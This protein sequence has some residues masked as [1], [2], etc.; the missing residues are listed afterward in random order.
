M[1]MKPYHVSYIHSSHHF[2]TK[3]RT[4]VKHAL[5]YARNDQQ[6][7]DTASRFGATDIYDPAANIDGAARYLRV[8]LDKL[9]NLPL[10]AAAYN[11]G[12][13]AVHDYH[14][15]PR[16]SEN[17]GCLAG[18]LKDQLGLEPP[19]DGKAGQELNLIQ[20]RETKPENTGVIG[21][22]RETF[23][24]ACPIAPRTW[25]GTRI[26]IDEDATARDV[27]YTRPDRAFGLL[28]ALCEAAVAN[29]VD[30][31]ISNYEPHMRRI[32]KKP[33]PNS[34][35]SGIPMVMALAGLLGDLRGF[36]PRSWRHAHQ[37]P[38]EGPLYQRPAFPS[39]IAA[40]PALQFS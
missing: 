6:L 17:V 23:P 32:I 29:C 37:T 31:M 21:V 27:P 7:Q 16:F 18:F 4:Y 36:A 39:R 11:A 38:G 14:G 13:Q 40:A 1:Y 33:G 25:D 2:M 24:D 15:T 5:T 30:T 34:M 10:A 22:F 35:N 28:L 9:R 12:E 3:K 26:G 8:P 19:A 20:S